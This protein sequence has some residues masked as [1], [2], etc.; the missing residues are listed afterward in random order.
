TF[1]RM[2]PLVEVT[3]TAIGRASHRHTAGQVRDR[4]RGH[5]APRSGVRGGRDRPP[6]PRIPAPR[7]KPAPP[8]ATVPADTAQDDRRQR[9]LCVP[10]AGG[11]PSGL[12]EPDLRLSLTPAIRQVRRAAAARPPSSGDLGA[13]DGSVAIRR[14]GDYSVD[15]AL[16]KLAKVGG[17]TKVM[18]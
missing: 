4:G 18:A 6:H 7:R 15:Y 10:D 13:G 1:L 8:A 2:N 16:V 9:P 14:I 11:W 3:V 12:V 17:K 5:R